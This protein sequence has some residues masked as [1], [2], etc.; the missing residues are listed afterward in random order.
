MA[1]GT[2]YATRIG[3]RILI[4]SIDF[5]MSMR[6]EDPTT[7]TT[8]YARI[9]LVYDRQTNGVAPVW[10]DIFEIGAGNIVT[11]HRNLV[12]SGRFYMLYDKAFAFGGVNSGGQ[13]PIIETYFKRVN[14]PVYYNG[15]TAG[16]VADI[17]TGSLYLIKIGT[18]IAGTDNISQSTH[19]RIRFT[20]M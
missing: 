11:A 3:K 5:R 4:K 14:M 18:S 15:G 13:Y 2:S 7:T 8:E 1:L 16:T 20:D 17:S 10:S 6:R 19:S 9:C 12:N